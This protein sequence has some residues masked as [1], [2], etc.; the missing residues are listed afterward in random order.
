MTH[1]L[2]AGPGGAIAHPLGSA[3]YDRVNRALAVGIENRARAQ[4]AAPRGSSPHAG[5]V[6][7]ATPLVSKLAHELGVTLALVS[8]SGAAGRI[9]ETDV[10]NAAGLA[11]RATAPRAP[12]SSVDGLYEAAWGNDDDATPELPSYPTPSAGL[13][14]TAGWTE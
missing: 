5:A 10:R 3:N 14:A 7:A 2:Y 11:P 13:E 6:P 8:G 9:T 1:S 12:R 4:A